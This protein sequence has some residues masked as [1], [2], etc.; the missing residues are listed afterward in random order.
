[1]T[2]IQKVILFSVSLGIL[3]GGLNTSIV[4]TVLPEIQKDLQL[5]L[6]SVQWIV[7]IYTLILCGFIL[8]MGRLGD[9]IG[10]KKVYQTGL[11]L[12][13][14]FSIGCGLT[15]DLYVILF[16]RAFQALGGAMIM[17]AVPAILTTAFPNEQRGKALGLMASTVY[18]GLSLGPVLGGWL[19]AWMGWSS[20]FYINLPFT[21]IALYIGYRFIPSSKPQTL[22]RFDFAGGILFL[23]SLTLM[24]LALNQGPISGWSGLW[25]A[26]LFLSILFGLLFVWIE[27]KTSV[28]MLQLTLLKNQVISLGILANISNYIVM[29]FFY[30][31]LPLYL[32]QAMGIPVF[33]VGTILAIAPITMLGIATF[34][35]HI[36][37]RIGTRIPTT[38]GMAVLTM[39]VFIFP[40][41]QS[42]ITIHLVMISCV[43]I[44]VGSGL[45]TS[46]NNSAVFGATPS[47]MR[48]IAS[49]LTGTAR[50]LGQAIGLTLAAVLFEQFQKWPLALNANHINFAFQQTMLIATGIG[51]VGIVLSFFTVPGKKRAV[52]PEPVTQFIKH[53]QHPSA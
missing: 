24:L 31:L 44:G 27:S 43:L 39:G 11:L 16:S 41:F 37:D 33:K 22:V 19:T 38:V 30:S 6:T 18:V 4:S 50:Y 9:L 52:E 12:F 42:G 46:P 47:S 34:S 23:M 25:L 1:M 15:Q 32:V 36:S 7:T 48:G 10:H 51:L 13:S 17:A 49:G 5:P 20:I 29:F 40:L 35:G 45:F 26:V 28:P 53:D 14:L 2:R 3:V 8:P 21:L